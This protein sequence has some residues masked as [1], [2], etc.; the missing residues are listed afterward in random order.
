LTHEQV[1]VL[2]DEAEQY[3][4]LVIMLCYCR[5]CWGEAAAIR[6]RNVDFL[7]RR[8]SLEQNAVMVGTKIEVGSLKGY[9]NR[10]VPM[11][12][13]VGDELA[14]IC[15][16]KGRDDLLWANANGGHLGPPASKD[17]WLSGAVERCMKADPRFPQV[18]A[19][20]LRH[21]AASLALSGREREGDSADDGP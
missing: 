17:S 5:P 4:A 13:F 2:A 16:G 18:T 9:K 14:K 15:S 11:P 1:H 20:L 8:I 21:S 10:Q 7:R 12:R 3:R 19:H 6:V